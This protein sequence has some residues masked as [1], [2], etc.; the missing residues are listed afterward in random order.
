[1]QAPSFVSANV[2]ATDEDGRGRL[3]GWASGVAAGPPDESGQKIQFVVE[4]NTNPGIF[5]VQPSVDASGKLMFTPKPNASGTA[6][7]TVALKDDGGTANGGVDTS[8]PQTFTITITKPHPWHNV[9]KAMDVDGDG[10]VVA[11]DALAVIDLINAFGAG[12]LTASLHDGN[13]YDVNGD[14]AASPIDA[15]A[16]H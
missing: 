16:D 3:E 6:E 13:F 5:S 9:I 15:A 11:G 4:G 12:S 2:S 1:M 8:E 10:D 7:V 14:N